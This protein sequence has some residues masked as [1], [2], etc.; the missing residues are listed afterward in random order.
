MQAPLRIFFPFPIR[1]WERVVDVPLPPALLLK[2]V[3]ESGLVRGWLAELLD[4][5]SCKPQP[6]GH[7]I[8]NGERIDIGRFLGGRRNATRNGP[9]LPQGQKPLVKVG[10]PCLCQEWL[11]D[12]ASVLVGL[13]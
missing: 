11:A 13:K 1:E 9:T 10:S 4:E 7:A 3:E 2:D 6:S 5:V 8:P 12:D